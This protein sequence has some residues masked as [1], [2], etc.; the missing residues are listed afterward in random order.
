M[1][2]FKKYDYNN[3]KEKRL[4]IYCNIHFR[5]WAVP[6]AFSFQ[7]LHTNER[8]RIHFSIL[9]FNFGFGFWRFEK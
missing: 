8:F 5:I 6:F 2:V 1:I 4:Q 3:K 7:R 9:C